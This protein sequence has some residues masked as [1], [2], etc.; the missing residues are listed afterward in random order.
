MKLKCSLCGESLLKDKEW[1]S[2]KKQHEMKHTL[3]R[4]NGINSIKGTVAW[5]TDWE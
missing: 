4:E 5:I 3:G 1:E 2:R